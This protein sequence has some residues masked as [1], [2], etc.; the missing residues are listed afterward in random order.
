MDFQ[1]DN[2]LV[3]WNPL[4]IASDNYTNLVNFIVVTGKPLK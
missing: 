2:L 3:H 1:Q 4:S